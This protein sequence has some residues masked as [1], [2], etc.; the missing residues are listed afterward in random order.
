MEDLDHGRVGSGFPRIARGLGPAGS[1]EQ[2]F[3]DGENFAEGEV[4]AVAL[5]EALASLLA[6]L[7]R[8][9]I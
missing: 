7:D 8:I 4:R 6:Q 3:P 5:K 1:G 2:I 9:K